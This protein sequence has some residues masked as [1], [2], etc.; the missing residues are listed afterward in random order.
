M[1]YPPPKGEE[2]KLFYKEKKRLY[3][4]RE[5]EENQKIRDK[6]E[7]YK[8]LIKQQG[9]HPL[10]IPADAYRAVKDVLK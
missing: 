4:I 10:R 8:T 9:I 1:G 5:E 6:Y 2:L 3:K 7:K